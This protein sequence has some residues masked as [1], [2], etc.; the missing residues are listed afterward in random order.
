MSADV[1]AI[2]IMRL[3]YQPGYKVYAVLDGASSKNLLPKISELNPVFQC[4]F[5]GE[6][7]ADLAQTAPY[8]V[9]LEYKH[10]FTTWVVEK[11]WYEHW[12]IFATSDANIKVLSK[13][14]RKY[15]MVND[16]QNNPANFRFYDPRVLKVFLSDINQEEAEAFFGPVTS[17]VCEGE[18]MSQFIRFWPTI[19]TPRQEIIN[20]ATVKA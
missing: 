1:F 10:P 19:D 3:L 14:F 15:L 20:L 8:L 2:P 16:G 17:Y 6:I 5:R 18:Q 9:H 7:A 12:G 11:G 4:L 13:H